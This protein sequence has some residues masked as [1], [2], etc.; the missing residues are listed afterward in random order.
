MTLNSSL[1]ITPALGD[2]VALTA[3]S[4]HV[5]ECEGLL[6]QFKEPLFNPFKSACLSLFFFLFFLFVAAGFFFIFFLLVLIVFLIFFVIS[7]VI[8]FLFIFSLLAFVATFLI[9]VIVVT[10]IIP[11]AIITVPF[12]VF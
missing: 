10:H 9:I 5:L 8:F 4:H 12:F 3:E 6:L 2:L 1:E 11:K 7:I